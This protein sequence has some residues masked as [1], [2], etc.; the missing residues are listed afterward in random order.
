M[1]NL[2]DDLVV[3]YQEYLL[4]FVGGRAIAWRYPVRGRGL[5]QAAAWRSAG[6]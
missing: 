5:L 6:R 3:F 1:I 2:A 4:R